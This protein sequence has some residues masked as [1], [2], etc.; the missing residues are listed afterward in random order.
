M[1]VGSVSTV[2]CSLYCDHLLLCH[3]DTITEG[4]HGGLSIAPAPLVGSGFIIFLHPPIQVGLQLLDGT[5]ELLAEGHAVELIQDGLVEA[6]TDAV[7]LRALGLRPRVVDVPRPLAGYVSHII[8]DVGVFLAS[9]LS[10]AVTGQCID[11]N[12]GEFTH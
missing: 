9:D 10:R 11:V 6:L 1:A 8:A 5:I 3:V 4:V 7:G 2:G 12:A